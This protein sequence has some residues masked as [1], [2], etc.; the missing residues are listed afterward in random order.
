[1]TTAQCMLFLLAGLNNVSTANSF[2]AHELALNQEI[3]EK[4]YQEIYQVCNQLNGK[5]LTYEVLQKMIYM[6]FVVSETLRRW[7][8]SSTHDRLVSKP[9][10]LQ[11]KNGN[12]IQL[13]AGDGVL[14]PSGAI[15][16]DQKYYQDP[17]KFDPE[18]FN[19]ENK[20]KIRRDTFFPFGTGPRNCVM[21]LML[22]WN[23]S[24]SLI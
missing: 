18:R 10:V 11:D 17:E 23:T 13:K 5:R 24:C 4:L 12:K 16:K 2:M 19:D 14:F 9:Y 7:T 22:S 3:Q 20:H 15:H 6:D 21:E 1:M 8:L